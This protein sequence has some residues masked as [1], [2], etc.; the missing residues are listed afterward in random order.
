MLQCAPLLKSRTAEVRRPFFAL[1]CAL[2]T[3]MPTVGHRTTY[4]V[5]SWRP[6]NV[7]HAENLRFRALQPRCTPWHRPC[8]FGG[9]TPS[10][11]S[12][13]EGQTT[14]R[15]N[16]P[17]HYGGPSKDSLPPSTSECGFRSADF[18]VRSA[19]CGVR[20]I[21]LKAELRERALY[22]RRFA[23]TPC[24]SHAARLPPAR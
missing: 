6:T 9:G 10:F 5:T 11:R 19:E 14:C 16:L 4:G 12:L 15:K 20:F 18:G 7:L 17:V 3:E 2:E 21:F 1:T 24:F 22:R 8:S 23:R 13:R